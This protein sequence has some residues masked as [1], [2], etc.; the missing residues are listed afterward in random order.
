MAIGRVDNIYLGIV[1]CIE[2][3]CNF[4]GLLQKWRIHPT[5]ISPED[6]KII[7]QDRRLIGSNM[8]NKDG[9]VILSF[10]IHNISHILFSSLVAH[11]SET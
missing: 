3:N 10:V 8:L 9:I 1:L 6:F 7:A 11:S 2:S 4:F 5:T